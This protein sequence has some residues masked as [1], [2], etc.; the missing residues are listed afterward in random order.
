CGSSPMPKIVVT[1]DEAPTSF[2][3]TVVCPQ[4][5]KYCDPEYCVALMCEAEGRSKSA[6]TKS[7]RPKVD[8]DMA[9]PFSGARP[10]CARPCCKSTLRCPALAAK[11]SCSSPL[12]FPITRVSVHRGG[13]F[14]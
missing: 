5:T 7:G 13:R 12:A 10:S 11:G 4:G 8:R 1:S 9:E 14:S 3:A 6:K 2:E